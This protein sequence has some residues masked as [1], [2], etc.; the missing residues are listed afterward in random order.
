MRRKWL[1]M[2]ELS[3]LS[4]A[5]D[6][7]LLE[8]LTG[9]RSLLSADVAAAAPFQAALPQP[10]FRRNA[11]QTGEMQ[12]PI[13]RFWPD[14]LK[15]SKADQPGLEGIA[16]ALAALT[17]AL[18]W[19][20]NPNYRQS[21]PNADF[22]DNYG[23]AEICGS[24]GLIEASIRFGVLILGPGTCY[25]SHRHPAEEIYLPLGVGDWQHGD[26]EMAAGHWTGQP[27]GT[28]I[29]HPPHV[30]HATRAN[31]TALAALYLWR[32]DLTTEAQLDRATP[33]G[34]FPS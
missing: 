3:M 8:L 7:A 31:D 28:L 23:Y 34:E 13:L 21:P 26:A 6:T 22:L 25:P 30:P 15:Q 2:R 14:C 24:Y 9:L 29:H 5:I 11:G 33:S 19:R 18:R 32:G 10:P 17:P 20:Q 27:V 12:L 16:M 4:P 1:G